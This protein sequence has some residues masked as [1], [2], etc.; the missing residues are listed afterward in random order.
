MGVSSAPHDV[1]RLN[2]ML[3]NLRD[4]G[5]TVTVIDHDKDVIKIADHIVDVGPSA[6]TNISIQ[7]IFICIRLFSNLIDIIACSS[8]TFFSYIKGENG[9]MSSDFR[10]LKIREFPLLL[11]SKRMGWGAIPS[12]GKGRSKSTGMPV[13]STPSCGKRSPHPGSEVEAP[14]RGNYSKKDSTVSLLRD[15]VDRL[16]L[17]V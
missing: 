1:R 8:L 3:Q 13:S 9:L 6:G 10:G 7:T 2:L 12:G 17:I 5:N 4:K 15:L 14:Y 11:Y 16:K